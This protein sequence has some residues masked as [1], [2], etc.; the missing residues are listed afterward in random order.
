MRPEF[1]LFSDMRP[2]IQPDLECA[3]SALSSATAAGHAFNRASAMPGRI[4]SHT[5]LFLLQKM[6]TQET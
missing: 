6:T 4:N 2:A 1:L 5:S 3:L